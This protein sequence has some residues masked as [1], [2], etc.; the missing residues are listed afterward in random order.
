MTP[1]P[2]ILEAHRMINKAL[3]A[4]ALS[5]AVASAQAGVILE[6]HFNNFS[7]LSAAGWVMTD[8]GTP[9]GFLTS[10]WY[11]GD[12]SVFAAHDGAAG[13]YIFSNYD[14]APVGGS[15]NNWMITPEF[16]TATATV[17]SLWLRGAYYP[18]YVDHVAFGF[19]SGSSAI[20]SFAMN[21]AIDVPTAGWTEYT[22]SFGAQGAG[23]TGRFAIQYAGPAD[24]SNYIGIDGLTVSTSDVTAAVPE[25]ATMLVMAGGLLGMAAARRRRERR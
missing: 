14:T 23:T 9:G 11:E 18:G 17:V 4:L 15:V 13:S 20:A 24:T 25:P 12:T 1:L 10:P 22:F 6:E 16:S 5:G 19:S 8:A 2:Y 21:P 3:I 7:G